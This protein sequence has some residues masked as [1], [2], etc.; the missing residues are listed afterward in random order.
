METNSLT[1]TQKLLM[2]RRERL[3]A[4]SRAYRTD[5]AF[6][7]RCEENP[8]AVLAEEGVVLPPGMEVRFVADTADTVHV[9]MP[10]DPNIPLSEEELAMA[11]GGKRRI[12]TDSDGRQYQLRWNPER[13]MF[14][15]DYNV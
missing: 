6:R 1:P 12:H 15:H 2:E 14:E 4:L 3:M 11:G 13:M 7:A 9:A 10:V 8:R 5:P